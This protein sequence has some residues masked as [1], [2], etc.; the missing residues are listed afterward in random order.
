MDIDGELA[1]ES[2]ETLVANI[3]CNCSKRN[4]HMLQL[5]GDINGDLGCSRYQ[6][7]PRLKKLHLPEAAMPNTTI[8]NV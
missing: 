3:F 5:L 8:S 1:G 7:R 2:P 4:I 6:H